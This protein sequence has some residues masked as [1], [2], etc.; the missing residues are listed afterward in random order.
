MPS[1]IQ[2]ARLAHILPGLGQHS[3]LSVGQMCESG[4]SVTFTASNVTVTKGH[5]TIL[6]GERDKESSL[7]RAPLNPAPPLHVGQEHHAH[8]VYEQKSIQDTI[9][10]L[11]AC[12]FSPVT[13]TWLK[14]IQNGHFAT[15]HSVTVENVRKY[16]GKSDATAKG[17]L[18]QIRQNIRSTQQV[19]I[20]SAPETDMVQ[21]DK[22]HYL[23]ATTLETNQVYS[24]LTGIFP[25]TSLSGKTYILILY[26]YDRNSV[27]STPKKNRSD[28]EM[29]RAFD[30]L[31]QSLILHGL[32]PLCNVWIM[33]HPW[34]LGII[35]HS[36]E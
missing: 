18:N 30:F 9:T 25:T 1:L 32:K 21:E 16:L 24:D 33:K 20:I 6:T 35:S 19:E 26:D 14:S 10:Y 3:L 28:K 23:H 27:L 2:A 5:S 36:R 4:F 11:H 22:C 29:V 8:N 7:W 12:F 13:D 17:H 31:I 34:H 15:W